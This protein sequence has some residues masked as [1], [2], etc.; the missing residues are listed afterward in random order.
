MIRVP[1]VFVIDE[2]GVQK[3][4][5][6]LSEALKLAEAAELDLVEVS[7]NA[8]PP[9]TKILDFGKYKYD[10]EKSAN[11]QKKNHKEVTIKEIRLGPTMGDHDL[12]VKV[13][14]AE[15]FLKEGN[16][17]KATVIFRGRQIAHL[18]LGGEV[19]AKFIDRLGDTAKMEQAPIR[20]GRSIHIIIAPK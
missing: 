17:L 5:M 19:L 20:Q 6:S 18:D 10:L 11:R 12:M 3:G 15:K 8:N 2:E 1:R 14:Q 7:P 9:V 16:K 4:E 13:K